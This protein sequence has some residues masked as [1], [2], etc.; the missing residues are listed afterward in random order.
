MRSSTSSSDPKVLRGGW[1]RTWAVTAA[2]TFLF[3]AGWEALWRAKGFEPFPDDPKLW[4]QARRRVRPDDT[5]LVGSSRTATGVLPYEYREVT[6]TAPIQLAIPGGRSY[7]VLENLARD[8]TFR[9]TVVCELSEKEIITG[10]ISNFEKDTDNLGWYERE[11]LVTRGESFLQLLVQKRFAFTSSDLTSQLS[12]SMVA[13]GVLGGRLPAPPVLDNGAWREER[14]LL[15][16][17]LKVRADI[18]EKLRAAYAS[19]IVDLGPEV[20]PE[21]F[22]VRARRFEALAEEIERRGGR[23]IFVRY[24]VS[25]LLWERL[26]KS[27]PKASYWDEFAR[28]TRFRTVHFKDYPELQIECPD[29]AHLDMRDAPRFTRALAHIIFGDVRR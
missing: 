14:T 9:G 2:L 4:A 25:G 23:V 3:L 13:R 12:L 10:R 1:P 15:L 5:V 24:P 6:G 28:R 18:L 22:I 26:E 16:D 17:F 11:T 8:P 27:Y 20:S 29:Y 21:E 19:G 7:L